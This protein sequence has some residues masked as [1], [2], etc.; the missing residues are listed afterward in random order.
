M[1]VYTEFSLFPMWAISNE[2]DAAVRS[3]DISS[4]PAGFNSNN[5]R[6][7]CEIAG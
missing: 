1:Y 2:E 3:R 5:T 7:I 6:Y 4:Y